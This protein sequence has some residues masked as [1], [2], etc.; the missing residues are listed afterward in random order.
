MTSCNDVDSWMMKLIQLD[1]NL[2]PA[3]IHNTHKVFPIIEFLKHISIL[4]ENTLNR[5]S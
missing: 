4:K 3:F 5:G 2:C 1:I